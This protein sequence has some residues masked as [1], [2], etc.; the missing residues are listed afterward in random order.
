MLVWCGGVAEP[1]VIGNRAEQRAAGDNR[2]THQF[3]IHDLVTDCGA[4]RMLSDRQ[5]RWRV[6]RRK[7]TG[8]FD[9]L[10]DEKQHPL[11]RHVLAKRHEVH[12]PVD[13]RGFAVAIDQKRGIVDFRRAAIDLVAA[14]DDWY[15]CAPRYS[16][17][18][19]GSGILLKKEWR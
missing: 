12:L 16:A 6:A 18:A 17:H 19:C 8:C 14:N 4:D 2:L 13:R 15:L 1:R 7:I 9:E 3:R 10:L 11:K 5:H